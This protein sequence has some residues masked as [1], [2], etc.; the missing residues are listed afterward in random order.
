MVSLC[1]FVGTNL[2]QIFRVTTCT[3]WRLRTVLYTLVS[4]LTRSHI[5]QK[6]MAFVK[7][8]A[9]N[10][11]ISLKQNCIFCGWCRC[12]I[13]L[14]QNETMAWDTS[15]ETNKPVVSNCSRYYFKICPRNWIRTLYSCC[16]R[17]LDNLLKHFQGSNLSANLQK[18]NLLHELSALKATGNF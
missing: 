5:I 7:E 15:W 16:D 4:P 6:Q 8:E 11:N 17:L 1:I 13:I 2:L 14:K 9:F 3:L 12:R 10:F 18:K